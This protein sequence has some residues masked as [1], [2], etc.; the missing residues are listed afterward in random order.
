MARFV[1]FNIQLIILLCLVGIIMT[2]LPL[3]YE[4][5][6]DPDYVKAMADIQFYT[7]A[8]SFFILYWDICAKIRR[9]HDMNLSLLNLLWLLIPIVNFY[10]LYVLFFTKGTAGPNKY[11]PDPLLNANYPFKESA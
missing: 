3:V 5:H 6:Y 2:T 9:F 4:S 10:F 7:N 1:Y 8:F 11:G